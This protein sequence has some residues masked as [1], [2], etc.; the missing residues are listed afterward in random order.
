MNDIDMEFKLLINDI[1]NCNKKDLFNKIKLNFL[2]LPYEYKFILENYFKRF[3]F[4]GSLNANQGDFTEIELKVKSLNNHYREIA[5]LYNRLDDYT[6]KYILYAVLNNW[7]NYDI[8]SLKKVKD[9]KYKHYFDFDL[10]PKCKNETIIDLGAYVG[11]SVLDYISCYGNNSYR[12]IYCYEI[13]PQMVKTLNENLKNFNNIVYKNNAVK[14]KNGVIYLC[15]NNDI[16]SNRT[17]KKGNYAIK[18]VTLDEDVKEKITLIKMDIEGDELLALKGAKEHI[19]N[20]MPKLLISIY[21]NNDHLWQIPKY[22]YSLNKNYKFYL[23]YYGGELYPT[24]LVLFA[25]PK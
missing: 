16:S 13:T 23:R 6:S 17:A 24:E 1:K 19:K 14:D 5:W 8:V 9:I 18:C 25:M 2:S 22:I 10:L 21:H 7:I 11:D 12:K 4:W 20:D 3:D 15:E